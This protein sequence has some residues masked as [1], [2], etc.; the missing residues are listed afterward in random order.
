MARAPLT[1]SAPY[2]P[3]PVVRL[4]LTLSSLVV[5]WD[6]GFCLTR[7][8]SFEGGDL[9]WLYRPYLLYEKTD[10]VYSR[11]AFEQG[12]GFTAAQAWMNLVE[13]ALNFLA[14][15]LFRRQ[16]PLGVLV[17]FTGTLM[18]ASKTILYWLYDHQGDWVF[19]GH[20]S[21]RD[22]WLL[23][24]LPNGLWIVF[25]TVLAVLFGRQIARSLQVAAK[26]KSL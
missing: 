9:F 5:L 13:T 7:P 18:T 19:T 10:F 12:Y 1:Q 22:W 3:G 20:N 14:L 21:R 15:F 26:T 8:R 24:A 11:A 25:P 2:S 17:G 16:S 6:A 23:F 4:W